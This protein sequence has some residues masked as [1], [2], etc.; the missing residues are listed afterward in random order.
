MGLLFFKLETFSVFL[1][2]F[3]KGFFFGKH[4]VNL[5]PIGSD[6]GYPVFVKCFSVAMAK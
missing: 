1:L 5:F 3:K 6:L 4:G 2:T